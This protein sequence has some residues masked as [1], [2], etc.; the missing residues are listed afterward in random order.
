MSGLI[1]VV[2]RTHTDAMEQLQEAYVGAV[3]ASAGATTQWVSRD[4]HKYDVELIRQPDPLVEQ[5]SV[6]LQL[7]STTTLQPAPGD[8]HIQFRF[9]TR[10]DFESLAMTRD[11]V[12]HL[13]VVM[14]VGPDQYKWTYS[15]HR[16]MLL[17]HCCYWLNLEGMSAPSNPLQPVVSVPLENVF[18][19]AA[20][21]GILDRI[22]GG[23]SL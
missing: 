4:L 11:S 3:A 7:K 9:K 15:H 14:L 6:R 18:D 12:K 13:L 10:E 16:A 23:E 19:S 17:R 5:A 1:K 8:T 22:E 20:L 21:T 2:E